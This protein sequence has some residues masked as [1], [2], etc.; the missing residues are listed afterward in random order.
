MT[1]DE[2]LAKIDER[3][4]YAIKRFGFDVWFNPARAAVELHKP[5]TNFEGKVV[6]AECC[7][8]GADRYPCPTTQAIEKEL[9]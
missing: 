1:H 7:N 2:L 8:Y 6:C 3:S 4:A 5:W 9:K